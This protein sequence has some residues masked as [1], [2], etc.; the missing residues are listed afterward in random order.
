MSFADNIITSE[1]E[2]RFTGNTASASFD[3]T[4]ERAPSL[5]DS[6]VAGAGD[7]N[8]FSGDGVDL[9]DGGEGSNQDRDG[10]DEAG[11]MA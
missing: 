5:N 1:F 7:D 11:M 2:V 6:I 3:L 4:G 8:I 9:V 10:G